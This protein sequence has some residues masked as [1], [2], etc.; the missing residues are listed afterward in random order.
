MAGGGAIQWDNREDLLNIPG[1]A[2]GHYADLVWE[3]NID[4]DY[5]G[6]KWQ[7]QWQAN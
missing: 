1:Y 6:Q 7:A 5:S 3:T 2:W 4:G